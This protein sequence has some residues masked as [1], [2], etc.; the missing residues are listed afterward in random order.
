MSLKIS[1]SRETW[2]HGR[3]YKSKSKVVGRGFSFLWNSSQFGFRIQ[4]VS[5][6]LI[7]GVKPFFLITLRFRAGSSDPEPPLSNATIGVVPLPFHCSFVL[8]FIFLFHN[9]LN[10]SSPTRQQLAESRFCLPE[11]SFC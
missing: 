7:L 3:F 10:L 2:H 4:T 11:V 6:F 5:L 9:S 8:L 1:F